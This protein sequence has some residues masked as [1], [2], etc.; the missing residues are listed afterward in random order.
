MDT[1]EPTNIGLSELAHTRLRRLKEDGHFGEMV[2]AYRVAVAL[3][4]ASGVQPPELPGTR[5]NIFNVGTVDPDRELYTA[6]KTLL[7]T[8]DIPVYRWAERLAEWGVTE[9]FRR[10]E[11]GLNISDLLLEAG[12]LSQE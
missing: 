2:D 5:S 1:P 11:L 8:G 6:I 3:A 9:L 12:P 7:S 10:S 4:L